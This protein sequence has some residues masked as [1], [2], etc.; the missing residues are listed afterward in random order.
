MLRSLTVALLLALASACATS[1]GGLTTAD[2]T[3][4]ERSGV[5]SMVAAFENADSPGKRSFIACVGVVAVA[6]AVLF[7]A[8]EGRLEPTIALAQIT[9]LEVVTKKLRVPDIDVEN[10]GDWASLDKALVVIEFEPVLRNLAKRYAIAFAG[11]LAFGNWQGALMRVR[12]IG[13]KIL[14]VGASLQGGAEILDQIDAGARTEQSALDSCNRRVGVIKTRL[15]VLAGTASLAPS[16]FP[17]T[18]A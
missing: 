6:S 18:G 8:E 15:S 1:D 3:G 9:Q 4:E 10:S 2:L 7:D 17:M 14:V 11:D 5:A 13:F 16:V 12:V